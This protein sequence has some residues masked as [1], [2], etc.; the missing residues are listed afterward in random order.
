VAEE[1]E[2]YQVSGRSADYIG[3]GVTHWVVSCEKLAYGYD[4]NGDLPVVRGR[5]EL[6]REIMPALRELAKQPLARDSMY[7]YVAHF[8]SFGTAQPTPWEKNTFVSMAYET[9][10][11]FMP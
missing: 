6:A 10:A 4:G 5:P 2:D 9:R 3:H 7:S 11:I 8:T 1:V